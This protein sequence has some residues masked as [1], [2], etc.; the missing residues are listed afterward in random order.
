MNLKRVEKSIIM[1][2]KTLIKDFMEEVIKS[3]NKIGKREFYESR[4]VK[5]NKQMSQ[6]YVVVAKGLAR[7]YNIYLYQ[8]NEMLYVDN[9]S[10]KM[11]Y[12]RLKPVEAKLCKSY[13]RQTNCLDEETRREEN[14]EFEKIKKEAKKESSKFQ[15]GD[16]AYKELSEEKLKKREREREKLMSYLL[17]RYPDQKEKRQELTEKNKN[18]KRIGLDGEEEE[19][20]RREK[21]RKE[22]EDEERVREKEESIYGTSMTLFPD[23]GEEMSM[24]MSVKAE[25]KSEKMIASILDEFMLI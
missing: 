6:F 15:F 7:T 20:L 4:R 17:E 9:K 2:T 18:L 14:L 8:L 5:Y 24:K 11:L 3:Q 12:I 25:S 1:T 19:S 23:L 16:N 21:K 13:Y 22:K 10:A